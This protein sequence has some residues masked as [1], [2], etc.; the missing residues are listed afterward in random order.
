MERLRKLRQDLLAWL[1]TLAP[2]ERVLV[3]LAALAVLLFSVWLV[4]GRVG[5]A[6]EAREERI[7]GK[8]R[9]LAQ[10]GKLAEEY[11][12]RQA[13]RGAIESRLRAQ[14]VPLMS[15]ISQTGAALGIDVADLRPTNAPTE[16]EGLKEDSVE[17]NIAKIELSKLAQLLQ[18]LEHTQGVVKV[19]RIRITTRQ[20]VPDL[21]DA[22]LV[23]STYQ[24]KGT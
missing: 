15:H 20:D 22:T 23:V 10:F 16:L 5:A 7:A 8:T 21:V 13:E 12:R 3:T 24:L 14:P 18:N 4:V 6:M 11:K 1:S 17:V 9:V 19:R 2:R